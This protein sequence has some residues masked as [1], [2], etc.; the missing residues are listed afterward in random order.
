MSM[1]DSIQGNC[2]FAKMISCGNTNACMTC[3]WNPKVKEA[4]IKQFTRERA[5]ELKKK[6][7]QCPMRSCSVLDQKRELGMTLNCFSHTC[8]LTPE[9]K[10]RVL[11]GALEYWTS[12]CNGQAVGLSKKVE[13]AHEQPN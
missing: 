12:K 3:G 2:K 11:A 5:N 4:R 6:P 9:G 8:E 7:K 1:N 13:N 10:C